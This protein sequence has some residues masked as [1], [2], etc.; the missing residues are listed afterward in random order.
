MT[1][2]TLK[3]QWDTMGKEN[4]LWAVLTDNAKWK[5]EE[6]FLTGKKEIDILL[7]DITQ[8]KIRIKCRRALDFGC[9]VGRL[10]QALAKHFQSVAGVDISPSMI[11]AARSFNQYPDTCRYYC[12]IAA[13]L[14]LFP[15]NHFDFI[16]STITL[17]HMEQALAKNYLREFLRVM[18]PHGL[19]VFQIPHGPAST[20]KGWIIRLLPSR[21]LDIVRGSGWSGVL[22]AAVHLPV[23]KMEMHAIARNDMISFL[24]KQGGVV[25]VRPDT[26]AGSGWVSLQYWVQK[27][28]GIPKKIMKK[29]E[30]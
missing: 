24:E 23:T 4:P 7:Q 21:L 14:S 13:D 25:T 5:T 18:T 27:P 2:T 11:E 20:L 9:G 19:L 1:I 3:D 16:Y 22:R 29:Y 10:S 6:F 8:M 28:L 17:Q 12:N 30:L 15:D 26:Q